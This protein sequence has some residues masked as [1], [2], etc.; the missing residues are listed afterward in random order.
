VPDNQSAELTPLVS[1]EQ[2]ENAFWLAVRM[3]VGR[4]K[5]H[6]AAEVSTGAG[7]Q[8]RT[9]DCYRGYPIG[10]PDWRPLDEGQKF[11]IASFVG[12]DLTTEWISFIGQAAYNL[13]D[14]EPDPGDL[15]ADTSDDT[16]KVVRAAIDGKFDR[17][18]KPQLRE[19][20]AR[21]M[22]RGAQLIAVGG[23]A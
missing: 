20:G 8:R 2:V 17:G 15:A 9:L 14:V 19:V 4:G 23:R 10:H 1:R 12:A 18:E 7:V 11:S 16:A 21:M 3:F 13:P 22:A 5:R 6:S